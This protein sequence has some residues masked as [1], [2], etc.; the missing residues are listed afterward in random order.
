MMAR[1]KH[2]PQRTCIVCRT[3]RDKR[4]LLRIVRTPEGQIIVDGT[5][6]ANGRGAYLCRQV[7]CL[8][9]GLRD[10]RLARALKAD[11]SAETRDAL[12]SQIATMVNVSV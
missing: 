10:K 1:Q 6:K 4:D 9:T 12:L 7:E 5:G 3:V 8:E 11:I 2:A